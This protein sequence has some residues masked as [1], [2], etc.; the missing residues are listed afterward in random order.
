L[1]LKFLNELAARNDRN[2]KFTALG[3]AIENLLNLLQNFRSLFSVVDTHHRIDG[4]H[5]RVKR[6][7]PSRLETRMQFRIDFCFLEHEAPRTSGIT[8]KAGLDI[9]SRSIAAAQIPRH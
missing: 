4:L 9:T 6:I 5:L 3:K 2:F 1:N 8:A 7:E